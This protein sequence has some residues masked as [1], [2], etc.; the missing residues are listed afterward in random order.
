MPAPIEIKVRDESF[1][2]SVLGAS[3]NLAMKKLFPALLN[4]MRQGFL[5]PKTKI[6][7]FGRTNLTD[8]TFRQRLAESLRGSSLPTS[9]VS[10][11]SK[12]GRAILSP[13]AGSNSLQSFLNVCTYIVSDDNY[14]EDK[15][16]EDNSISAL[17]TAIQTREAE[18]PDAKELNRIFYLALPYN[19][20]ANICASLKKQCSTTKG[21]NRFVLE[22]PFGRDLQTAL[23][24]NETLARK[25][26][27]EHELY[28]IDRYLGKEIVQNIMVMRFA[29][30]FLAP[31]WNRDNIKNVQILFK[32][33]F[34]AEAENRAV[35]YDGQGVV[36]DVIQ[37]HLLQVMALVGM[38]TPATLS[39]NDIRD[40]KLKVLRCVKPIEVSDTVLGQYTAGKEHKGYK[41]HAPD[42]ES[43]TPTYA[44]MIAHIKNE[45]W[46]GVPFILKA[47]KG[48]NEKRSEIRI[49]LREVPGDL[50]ENQHGPN[51]IVVRMQPTEEMYM[52]VTIKKP[53]LGMNIVNSEMELSTG[54]KEEQ[55][56]NE[57]AGLAPRRAYERLL[58]N[59]LHGEQS[60]FVG[61]QEL[62][63]AWKICEPVLK[64]HDAGQ[65]GVCAYPFGSRGPKEAEELRQSTGHVST[66]VPKDGVP[67][68]STDNLAK[69]NYMLNQTTIS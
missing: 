13:A 19:V 53:G 2:I 69:L 52:K 57:A 60:H 49:Q 23:Q 55:M 32:E 7:G 46:D 3:G 62:V 26:I 25:A 21:V 15:V 1:V 30:R 14:G 63:A 56:V 44:M 64:A 12:G 66:I 47:G 37:N 22:K 43:N 5:P 16:D 58:L 41:A 24:L 59:C 54:W 67:M 28:R 40:E 10:S 68:G 18:S 50:F 11:P 17:N 51:E 9:P 27:L 65:M 36:R 45:R 8:E 6:I 61:S 42:P 31:I 29:N 39:E 35:Y 48:L 4:M 38:E 20:V 33:P 34:G